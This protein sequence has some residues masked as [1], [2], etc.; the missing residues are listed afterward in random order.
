[1]SS[2]VLTIN[3][4]ATPSWS[5]YNYQ[6]KIGIYVALRKI[7]ELLEGKDRE[8]AQDL[9]KD[10]I[11]EYETAEDFDLKINGQ[12]FSRHQVKAKQGSTTLVSIRDVLE[13]FNVEGVADD[14]R[15]LHSL[16][17]I[18]GLECVNQ[19]D[20][21][22]KYISE[23]L[24]YIE[25]PKKIQGYV[26]CN[27]NRFCGLED[28]KRLV[29]QHISKINKTDTSGIAL[30][31]AIAEERFFYLLEKIDAKVT[32][33]HES[34]NNRPIFSFFEIYKIVIE[35]DKLSED[36]RDSKEIRKLRNRLIEETEKSIRDF[37]VSN[38]D[39]TDTLFE[40]SQILKNQMHAIVRLPNEDFLLLMKNLHIQK[41]DW[42]LELDD[43]G[44]RDVILEYLLRTKTQPKQDQRLSDNVGNEKYILTTIVNS[45]K[46]GSLNA[47]LPLI[48]TI[49]RNL[50]RDGS[51]SRLY[52]ADESLVNA[53]IS[54]SIDP[55]EPSFMQVE[56]LN[57][58]IN[59]ILLPD[60]LKLLKVDEAIKNKMHM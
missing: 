15:W 50:Q 23:R 60:T 56:E 1:M 53:N 24:K 26:Y 18:R 48:Q 44:L 45:P 25:N 7:L 49:L 35:E 59:S 41:E 10:W 47:Q 36:V 38:S 52:S 14:Q 42:R 58:N 54:Q 31:D 27:E 19:E 13:S 28:I 11:L 39:L 2:E 21:N 46:N 55:R 6:G 43:N 17:N 8:S 29:I 40:H 32:S 30:D 16:E 20:F 22:I 37:F 57:K 3:R 33:G 5:G 34:G 12:V 4:N 51:M 9:L